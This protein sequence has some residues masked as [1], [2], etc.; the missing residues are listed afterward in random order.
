M[1]DIELT[2]TCESGYAV[3]SAVGEWELTVDATG[4]EGPT[5]QEVLAADYASCYVPAFRVGASQEGIEDVG[6]IEVDVAAD[7]DEDD[8]LASIAFEIRVEA[9]LE[10]KDDAVVARGEDICHVH[11]ALREELHADISVTDEAF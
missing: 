4:E 7:L 9:S 6:R 5:A 11:D 3:T 8:D 1:A 10:G 2:S